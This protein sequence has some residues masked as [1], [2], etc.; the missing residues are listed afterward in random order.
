MSKRKRTP[1]S[2]DRHGNRFRIRL[3]VNG[4]A[5]TFTVA[6]EDRRAAELFAKK[7]YEDLVK[8]AE[9]AALGFVV[10]VR[11]SE[12][13]TK[14][15][16]QEI[17]LLAAG[18]QRSYRETIEILTTY[19]VE[20]QGDPTVAS[21]RPKHIKEYLSWRRVN[22][23]DGKDPLSNRTIEKERALLHRIFRIAERLEYREGNPVALVEKPRVDGR[24]PVLLSAEQLE[25]LLVA[26]GDRPMLKLY[27]LF[28]AESGTRSRSEALMLR[29]D[30]VDLE[31][32]FIWVASRSRRRTKDAPAGEEHRPHRTKSGKGR[33][34]P[35]TPR[36]IQALRDH[37]A[38]Y[39]MA[40]YAGRRSPWVF[41][42]EFS[43]RKY[44]AGERIKAMYGSLKN[45]AKRASLPE[46]FR[47]HDL[48]HRRVTTW[49]A[50]EKN[51]VHVKEAVGHSSLATTM[52]YTHLAREHLK[53][54]VAEADAAPAAPKA[55]TQGKRR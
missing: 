23:L 11:F 31:G 18:T 38:R 49:L 15:D 42:H 37:A 30:D 14:F 17:P 40:T 1:G 22:R 32:G 13:L 44:T 51:P 50:E 34:V 41:H 54:L 25:K 43:R 28:L 55:S 36:L 7:K 45:A 3:S 12:L 39:R 47:L 46:G 9:R 10:G 5:H 29:W 27:V 35:I 16:E 4:T 48:R 20:Q 8:E 52:K 53:S 6:T 2:I 26:I 24:D 33:W 21:I 19:F